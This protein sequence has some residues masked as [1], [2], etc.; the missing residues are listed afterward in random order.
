[1]NR[2]DDDLPQ[3]IGWRRRAG[4]HHRSLA[5]GV[6]VGAALVQVA[7]AMA[8]GVEPAVVLALAPLL[9]WCALVP[10]S[11]LGLLAVAALAMQWLITV[12]GAAR[13]GP[14]VLVAAVGLLVLHTAMAAG[15]VA[16][17]GA[18]WSASMVRRWSVRVVVVAALTAAVWAF[19]RL[20]DDT[21]DRGRGNA[22]VLVIALVGTA[23]TVWSIRV[24]S[25]RDR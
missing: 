15:T 8:G 13:T 9:A 20:A 4:T 5:V 12:D 16:A 11:D 3:R 6:V 2:D 23:A 1:M 22:V 21:G 18:R 19:A 24:R 25:L 14:W 10:D 17:P 7:T